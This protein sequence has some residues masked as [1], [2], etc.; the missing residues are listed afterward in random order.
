MLGPALT[1]VS[2]IYKKC[3]SAMLQIN[4]KLLYPEDFVLMKNFTRLP[5][6]FTKRLHW[7]LIPKCLLTEYFTISTSLLLFFWQ[8]WLF[9]IHVPV[10]VT[11]EKLHSKDEYQLGG[12]VDN[13][14]VS[15]SI[16]E[17]EV[18][19]IIDSKQLTHT[20]NRED[21]ASQWFC[22]HLQVYNLCACVH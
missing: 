22:V 17:A 20:R 4:R 19:L 6:T 13:D 9:A 5:L 14:E 18:S 10:Q 12:V 8:T 1:Q 7:R 15:P 16:P 11:V 3:S 21:S 2:S